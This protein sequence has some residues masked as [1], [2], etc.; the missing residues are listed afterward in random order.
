MFAQFIAARAVPTRKERAVYSLLHFPSALGALR[1]AVHFHDWMLTCSCTVP[2]LSNASNSN[3]CT[4]FLFLLVTTPRHQYNMFFT[5]FSPSNCITLSC[6]ASVTL[7]IA[8][9]AALFPKSTTLTQQSFLF[10]F[11]V[12]CTTR[13][14][15]RS[16]FRSPSKHN[17]KPPGYLKPPPRHTSSPTLASAK[18]NGEYS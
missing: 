2:A 9:S 13:V 15:L 3:H 10:C 6:F 1:L 12:L 14:S 16:I 8:P 5:F 4:V 7:T 18:R 11:K 17:H